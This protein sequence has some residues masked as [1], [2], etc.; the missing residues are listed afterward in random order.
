MRSLILVSTTPIVIQIFNLICKKLNI[1]IEVLSE[2]QIDHK[3]DI[4]IIDKE[5]IDDRFTILKTYSKRIGAITNDELP[6][7]MAN[8][9]CIPSP[10]LPSSLQTILEEQLNIITKN[11][12]SK[13]YISNIPVPEN[14]NIQDIQLDEDMGIDEE[15]T[16]AI[17]YLDSIA[18]NIVAD[19]DEEND[20][21]VV[22]TTS[23]ED[24]GVL[25]LNELSKIETLIEPQKEENTTLDEYSNDDENIEEEWIDL[26]SII[27]QAINEVNTTEQLGSNFEDKP[28][29]LLLNNYSLN[30]LKPL[31]T[32]LNQDIIDS[33]TDGYEITLKLK[34]QMDENDE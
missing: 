29:N 1:T 2:A 27:D 17:D 9:F 11:A 31:F 34:L 5:F 12:N 26:A 18:E 6:F 21:S 14:E 3:V 22:T 7:E 4:I 16:P 10:F 30:E 33:L 15:L 8:D 28:I 25:D 24:G 19:I 20:D 13:T 23:L 32:L